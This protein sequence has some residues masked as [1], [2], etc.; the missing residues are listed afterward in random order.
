MINKDAYY[1]VWLGLSLTMVMAATLFAL[2]GINPKGASYQY[3]PWIYSGCC[4]VLG[5]IF[6]LIARRYHRQITS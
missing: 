4:A 6:G 5:G 2:V 1:L 3:L